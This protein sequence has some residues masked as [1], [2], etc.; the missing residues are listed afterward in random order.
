MA[1]LSSWYMVS[2]M[3]FGRDS[4]SQSAVQG[5]RLLRSA[6]QDIGDYGPSGRYFILAA[7]AFRCG[8]SARTLHC[9]W[10]TTSKRSF[11]FQTVA[12]NRNSSSC[13]RSI[14]KITTAQ[15]KQQSQYRRRIVPP[16]FDSVSGPWWRKPA[17][18]EIQLFVRTATNGARVESMHHR[19]GS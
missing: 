12:T 19:A 18:K 8:I 10:T 4:R 13:H 3:H 15:S 1:V 17:A 9:R 11:R 2:W 16:I 14:A 5:T 6:A 7:F